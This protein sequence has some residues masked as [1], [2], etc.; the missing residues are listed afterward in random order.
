MRIAVLGHRSTQFLTKY[1]R[2]AGLVNGLKLE[3]YE[4]DYDQVDLEILNPQSGLYESQADAIFIIHSERKLRN[5]FYALEGEQK[6]NFAQEILTIYEQQVEQIIAQHSAQII[7]TNLEILPD[8]IFGHFANQTSTAF[9]NQLR[10]IN[11]GLMDLA[12]KHSAVH[13]LDVASIASQLGA[14]QF[15]DPSLLINADVPYSRDTE[16]KIAWDCVQILNVMKGCLRKCLILDLDNTLWG[17]VIG[18]DGLE[19]IQLGNLGI[20]KAFTD[21]QKWVKQLQERGI[22]LAICSKNTESIAKEAFEKHPDMVLGLEDIA[23][24]VANWSNKADNL[25][26]IQQVLNIGFDSMVFLDDNPAERELIRLSLPDILVPELPTDPARYLPFL[27]SL[28]LFETLS[29]SANDQARTRQYQEEAK[30]RSQQQ[31]FTNMDDFLSS[32]EMKAHIT[33]F[34]DQQIPRIAQLTQRSN[35]F[36]LRTI[37]YSE[38][39]IKAIQQSDEYLTYAVSLQDKFGDYGLISVLILKKESATRL[40][41]DTWLMS[42]R[43]LKRGV[44]KHVLNHLASDAH[45][46]GFQEMVGE[47][48]P[49]AKNQIVAEHYAELAFTSL[50]KNKWHLSLTNWQHI[51]HYI[52]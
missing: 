52:Q 34:Q 31:A 7:F 26:H 15:A 6:R 37:R 5:Q 43:V 38:S 45:T 40:F 28:N 19:G 24:F 25:R 22:I 29:Y 10:R 35:Q 18:D 36:N 11:V 50:S 51:P 3:I 47:Y 8:A 39:D 1:L 4:A 17:G 2:Q 41:I 23:V 21:V 33:P 48:L 20:G 44:E 27:S 32:L 9:L 49:T 12:E 14:E 42:C 46:L 13:I 30:R 16:A